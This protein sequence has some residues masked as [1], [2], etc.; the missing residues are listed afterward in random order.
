MLGIGGGVV[1]VPALIVLFETTQIHT[2]D[3]ITVI[4]I[5]T[6]LSCIVFTS[7]SAAITQV[8][9]QKVRWDLFRKLVLFFVV[10]SFCAGVLTPYVPALTLRIMIGGFL[11]LVA[12]VMLTSWKP[13]PHKSM[14]GWWG[15]SL[16][17]YF[18]GMIAGTAGIAGGNVIVPTL[19]YFNTPAHNATATSS[20]LG[21]PIAGAGALAYM[22][23]HP[24]NVDSVAANQGFVDLTSFILITVFAVASA[25]LGVKFAHQVPAD[26]LKKYFGVL[27]LLVSMRM[28]YSA[29]AL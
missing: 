12:I 15:S 1:I 29:L 27:L 17:G 25:P 26:R 13:A 24:T 4:A 22:L 6:S 28:V 20:A 10:G 11:F 8:R 3:Q 18:G 23:W 5:A 14:P 2:H 7:L 9:A 19:V 16:I 21:V